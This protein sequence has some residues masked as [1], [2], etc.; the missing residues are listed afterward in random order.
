MGG[1]LWMGD[2]KI[3]DKDLYV[4]PNSFTL[5]DVRDNQFYQLWE[6][7]IEYQI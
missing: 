2:L 7:Q 3:F 1:G 5:W 4:I 6:I